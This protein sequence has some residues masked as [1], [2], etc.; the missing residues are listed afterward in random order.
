MSARPSLPDQVADFCRLELQR[1]AD[2]AKAIQMAAYMKTEMPFYGVQKTDPDRV[3]DFLER[4]SDRLSGL[5]YRE[6]ARRLKK[7]GYDL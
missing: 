2:P 3:F 1:L 7:L 5:S 4:N 6:G